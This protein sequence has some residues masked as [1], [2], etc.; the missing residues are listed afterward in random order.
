MALI[1]GE[2]THALSSAL[3]ALAFGIARARVGAAVMDADESLQRLPDF[4]VQY[5]W[6]D[7]RK[8]GRDRRRPELFGPRELKALWFGQSC[9]WRAGAWEEFQ[10]GPEPGSEA[11]VAARRWDPLT[12]LR[13]LDNVDKHRRLHVALLAPEVPHWFSSG[14]SPRGISVASP[15]VDGQI[16]ARVLDPPSEVEDSD[17][18]WDLRLA[19][20]ERGIRSNLVDELTNLH[21]QTVYALGRV[22]QGLQASTPIPGSQ[23][24]SAITD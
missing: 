8:W 11:E 6:S 21:G 24:D 20:A 10:I 16:V 18:N 22:I 7:M 23:D 9:Y 19:F 2:V 4:P 14:D 12:R 17:I 5:S 13:Y 3:D 1:A 15:W